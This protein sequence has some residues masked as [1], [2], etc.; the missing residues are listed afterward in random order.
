MS[1]SG[2]SRKSF[3]VVS[4]DPKPR[5]DLEPSV[6]RKYGYPGFQYG[7]FRHYRDVRLL[8]ELYNVH[9]ALETRLRY[10]GLLLVLNHLILTCYRGADDNIGYH[11]DKL[12]DITPNTAIVS[13][14]LGEQA[15]CDTLPWP[16]PEQVAVEE[17][18]RRKR[19]RSV[20]DGDGREDRDAPPD[21]PAGN[22]PGA[23][24][25]PSRARAGAPGGRAQHVREAERLSKAVQAGCAGRLYVYESRA[26]SAPRYTNGL[27][28]QCGVVG[29]EEA[30]PAAERRNY[31]GLW[32]HAACI[33]IVR[34]PK[35]AVERVQ[36]LQCL[37][38]RQFRPTVPPIESCPTL[39]WGTR[40]GYR[41]FWATRRAAAF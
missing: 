40:R 13:L 11:A 16:A 8:A 27:W 23:A 5:H 25:G 21:E 22:S 39:Q 10:F 18:E 32:L 41:A 6:L 35:A 15:R 19:G 3:Y 7:S 33:G 31:C 20:D 14:S 12:K 2:E 17:E 9:I 29:D 24:Q 36:C 37:S 38:V 28:I 26:L 34:A 1:S 4:D 30:V